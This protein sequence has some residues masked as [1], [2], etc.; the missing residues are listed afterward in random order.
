LGSQIKKNSFPKA[1]ERERCNENKT[2]YH[3]CHHHSDCRRYAN[4]RVG[5]GQSGMVLSQITFSTSKKWNI[6]LLLIAPAV[7][8][9]AGLHIPI[10]F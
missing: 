5:P 4:L 8:V 2:E 6:P 10:G 9:A 3:N 1:Y 7:G